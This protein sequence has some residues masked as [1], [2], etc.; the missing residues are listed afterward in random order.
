MAT[1]R[2]ARDQPGVHRTWDSQRKAA[3][4]GVTRHWVSGDPHDEHLKGAALAER[5]NHV[6][7]QMMRPRAPSLKIEDQ[8]KGLAKFTTAE[9]RRE[10]APDTAKKPHTRSGDLKGVLGSEFQPISSAAEYGAQFPRYNALKAKF[11]PAIIWYSFGSTTAGIRGTAAAL[12]ETRDIEPAW[13]KRQATRGITL[14]IQSSDPA[15]I[16]AARVVVNS[17]TPL[18]NKGVPISQPAL[19]PVK[20]GVPIERPA[21]KIRPTPA[22]TFPSRPDKHEPDRIPGRPGKDGG[23]HHASPFTTFAVVTA[24]V[25]IPVVGFFLA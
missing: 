17:F 7:P 5:V 14:W 9:M 22:S 16:N 8:G 13:V 6:K 1:T 20:T 23:G 11:D 19:Q 21:T 12:F 15:T 24:L 2:V 10:I 25:A 4:A 18:D 3:L